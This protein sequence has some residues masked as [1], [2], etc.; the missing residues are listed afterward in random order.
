MNVAVLGL[1][2]EGKNAIKALLDYGN[3][4][5]ASDLNK[6]IVIPEFVHAD[7]DFDLG[8]HDHGKINATDAVVLSPSLWNKSISKRI[9]A[10]EKLLSDVLTAHKSVFTVG[11][12]GTNGKTTTCYMIRDILEKSG[13]KILLGGNAGGG[14]D[15][16][17]KVVLE[18]SKNKV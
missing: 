8:L 10:E 15:G 3:H 5:Y 17:T 1:G 9:I 16:Y 14:F 2:I 6:D 11:V 18:A 4:V 12:T 7:L 13:L